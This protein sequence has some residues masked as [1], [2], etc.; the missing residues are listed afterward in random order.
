MDEFLDAQPVRIQ[1]L[2]LD[3]SSSTHIQSGH[4]LLEPRDDD[5]VADTELERRSV[6]R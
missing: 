2:D 1:R 6:R 5:R 3:R 4:A